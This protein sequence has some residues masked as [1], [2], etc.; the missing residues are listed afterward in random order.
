MKYGKIIFIN[1]HETNG[2]N[3]ITTLIL[4]IKFLSKLLFENH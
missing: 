1:T 2:E 3:V 4:I